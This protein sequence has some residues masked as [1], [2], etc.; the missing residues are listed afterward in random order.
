MPGLWSVI[1]SSLVYR[2]DRSLMTI[3]A[4]AM[5]TAVIMAT[6]ATNTA[7]DVSL[8]ESAVSLAGQT[9]L[10]IEAP[11]DRGLPQSV[12]ETV[13][14]L[15]DVRVASPQLQKRVFYR[16][17]QGRGFAELLGVD[18]AFDPQ[19]RPYR[20]VAGRMFRSDERAIMVGKD[21]AQAANLQLGDR[22]EL[23]SSEG[24]RAFPVVGLLDEPGVG[25]A[26]AGGLLRMPLPVAQ[27][28]FGLQD[29][30]QV[31]SVQ[32]HDASRLIN[33]KV[34]LPNRVPYVF[35][36]RETPRTLAFLQDSIRDLQGALLLFG[37]V[38]LL[39]GGFLMFNTLTLMVAEQVREIGL[40]RAAGATRGAV[41][42]LA[43]AQ[44]LILG[45]VGAL[46][47][48]V[49]GQL[50]AAGLAAIVGATQGIAST[51]VP[52]SPAGM[53][54]SLLLALVAAL[55]ASI[56]PA[57]Q[58]SRILP[59]EAI[60]PRGLA[61]AERGFGSFPR[62]VIVAVVA[63]IGLWVLPLSDD[64][65]RL[66]KVGLLFLLFPLFVYGARFTIPIVATVCA[67]PLRHLAGGSGVI[68]E[69]N[70]QRH[71]SRTSLTVAAFVISL[72]L[73]VALIN[74]ANS[75]TSAGQEW[76]Q[77]LFPGSLVVVSPVDQPVQLLGEFQS[78]PG[79][80]QASPISTLSLGW[81][82]LRLSAVGV[83]PSHYF[84]AF[85]FV[86][87]DRTEAFREMRRG[88]A[89]LLPSRLAQEENIALGDQM[90]LKA[91]DR[92]G[93]FTVVGIIAHSF[94]TPDNYGAI[95]L[96][97]RDVANIYEVRT[98]RFLALSPT[99]TSDIKV[100]EEQV[101]HVAEIYGMESNSIANL[102][103]TIGAEVGRLLGML[104]VLVAIGV[105]V[106]ALSVFNTMIMNIA[107]RAPEIAVLRSEGMTQTEIQRLS[108]AEAALMGL[109]GA[110]LGLGLG[111]LI[112]R[113]VVDVNRTP[114]FDPP[115]TFSLPY[116]GLV[117]LFGTCSAAV[118]AFYPAGKA[119][120]MNI[121]DALR[122]Q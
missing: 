64:R 56:F 117:L 119:A 77:S 11:D 1:W 14:G 111:T 53:G 54:L 16:T 51:D 85:R 67:L 105:V 36:V 7:L 86:Q 94:P 100:L 96:P 66:A 84:Q 31:L 21:W 42:L 27:S 70:F 45:V 109:L 89:I 23:I 115:F 76:A 98:F 74:G 107:Q 9:H 44:G 121:V 46:I 80:E 2:R 73:I 19:I 37:T 22:V 5:G 63:C 114:D 18:P 26:R 48:L 95:V 87:G 59:L 17:S 57:V 118:A 52:F 50:L 97:Q 78:L 24:F 110:L 71:R 92:Q 91:A 10:V 30:I 34:E 12:V 104:G 38:S 58:A 28:V 69:R 3:A 61:E 82:G 20:L 6:F 122:H 33:V 41:V 65:S 106:G 13:R 102:R 113:I 72:A 88:Q 68:A 101:S 93:T 4:V 120:R 112:T 39:A 29:R 116:A 75:F 15:S 35:I 90:L 25:N 83:D 62:V 103:Q 43:L 8:R 49:V 60:A 47:G 55:L 81:E 79:V 32:L 40:L 99:P 108:V